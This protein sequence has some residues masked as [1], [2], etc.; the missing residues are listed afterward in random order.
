WLRVQARAVVAHG[1][2]EC[3][4]SVELG[5]VA[6]DL[7]PGGIGAGVEGVI[8]DIAEDLPQPE[9]VRRAV[10]VDAVGPLAEGILPARSRCLELRPRLPPDLRQVAGADL[11]A[12]RRRIAPHILEK[13]V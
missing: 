4:L 8:Q 1:D 13:T 2:A 3:R 9:G 12:D 6:T 10:Q 5:V 11:Q 7:D